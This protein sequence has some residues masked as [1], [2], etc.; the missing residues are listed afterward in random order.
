MK[1]SPIKV[2]LSEGTVEQK[3][4]SNSYV[5]TLDFC[6]FNME[7]TKVTFDKINIV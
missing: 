2:E 7:K 3:Y 6:V 5:L 4:L 1:P